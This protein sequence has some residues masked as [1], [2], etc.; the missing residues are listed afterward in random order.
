MG[1]DIDAVSDIIEHMDRQL[2]AL[3]LKREGGFR[4]K[5]LWNHTYV[6]HQ[7]DRRRNHKDFKIQDHTGRKSGQSQERVQDS[8]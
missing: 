4:E 3:Y 5:R 8:D 7:I 6:K 1:T 2:R